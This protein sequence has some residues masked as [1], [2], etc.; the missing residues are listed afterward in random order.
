MAASAAAVASLAAVDAAVDVAVDVVVVAV[1]WGSDPHSLDLIKRGR[2]CYKNIYVPVCLPVCACV[3]VGLSIGGERKKR[4]EVQS[5][6]QRKV[7]AISARRREKTG[8]A[9]M[10][11]GMAVRAVRRLR[12]FAFALPHL[13]LISLAHIAADLLR[14]DA[15]HCDL[16]LIC[17]CSCTA[18]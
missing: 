15:L 4:D 8:E 16:R 17:T 11:R 18:G 6:R 14:L 7:P 1:A 3:Y 5:E 2:Q 9:E 10:K 12:V 13:S